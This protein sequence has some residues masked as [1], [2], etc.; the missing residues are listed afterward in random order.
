MGR[1]SYNRPYRYTCTRD[2]QLPCVN[3]END[4]LCVAKVARLSDTYREALNLP[5]MIEV[6]E[7][8]GVDVTAHLS[9]CRH[10]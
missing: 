2:S 1:A 8:V 9:P 10:T 4:L 5:D 6:K 7:V 3:V